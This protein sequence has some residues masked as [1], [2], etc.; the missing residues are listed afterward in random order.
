MGFRD[1][2][3]EQVKSSIPP[4]PA[5]KAKIIS[6]EKRKAQLGSGTSNLEQQ[7]NADLETRRE[8]EAATEYRLLRNTGKFT[9][10]SYVSPAESESIID[11]DDM[12]DA[13]G[14]TM[15]ITDDMERPVPMRQVTS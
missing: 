6:D 2:L 11:N 10:T 8:W 3:P 15:F 13:D 9:P 12:L 1:A 14:D 5:G 7:T 4:P